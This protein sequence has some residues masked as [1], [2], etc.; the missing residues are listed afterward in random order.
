MINS[1]TNIS[2]LGKFLGIW[3]TPN[4]LK[5]SVDCLHSNYEN[6]ITEITAC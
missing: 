6:L 4:K 5:I 2:S 3:K 1:I